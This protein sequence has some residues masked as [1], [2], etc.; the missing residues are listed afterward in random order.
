MTRRSSADGGWMPPGPGIRGLAPPRIP[1][2]GRFCQAG[3]AKNSSGSP[4]GSRKDSADPYAASWMPPWL[5]ELVQA[6]F[7]ALQLGPVGDSEGDVVQ[8]RAALGERCRGVGVGELMQ[9]DH[10]AAHQPHDVAERPGVLVEDG[11]VPEQLGVPGDAHGQ[12]A[13]G[14]RD[15]G[16]GRE[17]GHDG[18]SCMRMAPRGEA[19]ARPI[20]LPLAEY[21]RSC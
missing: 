12:V 6:L 20:V 11:F 7:P 8:A 2:P 9:A 15:V 21:D 10:R 16:D 1:G 13:D 17:S 4:S 19:I 5:A 18:S 3:G 14:Q